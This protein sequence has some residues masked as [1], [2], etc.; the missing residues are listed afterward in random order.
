[1][2]ANM[3]QDVRRH[4]VRRSGRQAEDDAQVRRS[5][6]NDGPMRLTLAR[7][8]APAG[9]ETASHAGRP[10]LAA[11][12]PHVGDDQHDAALRSAAA[13]V[14]AG[15]EQLA[16]QQIAARTALRTAVSASWLSF[17]PGCRP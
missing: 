2:S 14:D 13:R 1:M 9:I 12:T 15:L 3:P 11:C 5:F 10:D 16:F 7:R 17:S 8:I 4:A 6:D